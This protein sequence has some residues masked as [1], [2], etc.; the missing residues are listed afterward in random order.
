M[1]EAPLTKVSANEARASGLAPGVTSAPALLHNA[2]T[3]DEP[4]TSTP[5]QGLEKN[6]DL[7]ID[8]DGLDDDSPLLQNSES[9]TVAR[10]A[11][12]AAVSSPPPCKRRRLPA[13]FSAAQG[14]EH[15]PK[16]NACTHAPVHSSAE[17][18]TGAPEETLAEPPPRS[19]KEAVTVALAD[20]PTQVLAQVRAGG[21]GA[22]LLEAPPKATNE[23]ERVAA[24]AD[25]GKES[26]KSKKTAPSTATQVKTAGKSSV[27]KS[28][29][30]AKAVAKKA[31]KQEKA[32]DKAAAAEATAEAKRL[33]DEMKEANAWAKDK[34]KTIAAI[35]ST[36]AKAGAGTSP[37]APLKQ[38]SLVAAFSTSSPAEGETRA[39]GSS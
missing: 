34:I 21:L 2:D 22:A 14:D 9:T 7:M 13:S 10:L 27:K 1:T 15:P 29:A 33:R 35:G 17:T 19:P 23:P 37:K 3:V 31:A 5:F 26:S 12:D 8:L 16:D 32:A 20:A 36:K 25:D 38:V 11:G 30:A 6:D 28:E 39:G 18:L 4:R 24:V